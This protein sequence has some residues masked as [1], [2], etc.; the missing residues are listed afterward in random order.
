MKKISCGCDDMK[1]EWNKKYTTISV[2]ILIVAAIGMIV[3]QAIANLPYIFNLLGTFIDI[4]SPFLLG[5]V[6]AYILYPVL[7]L[8]EEVVLPFITGKKLSRRTYR[9]LSIFITILLGISAVAVLFYFIIPELLNNVNVLISQIAAYAPTVENALNEFFTRFHMAESLAPIISTI[10]SSVQEFF[11]QTFVFISKSLG[12]VINATINLTTTIINIFVGVFIAIYLWGSKEKFIAQT[13]KL[14]YAYLPEKFVNKAI[15]L[16]QEA[17]KIFGGFI[18]GKIVDSAIIGVLCYVGMLI[19]DI[20]YALLISVIVGVTNI[21]PYFGPFIGAIPS[22]LLL[23]M[24]DPIEALWF[25]VFVLVLQQLDGSIIGPKI[26]GE[27]TGLTAIWVI[28]SVTVF[29]GIF[30]F[31]GMLVGV[32]LFAMIYAIVKR[33][34]NDRL[35]KKNLS[36]NTND[37]A[38]EEN[39][40]IKKG[41]RKIR[42]KKNEKK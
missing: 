3:F 1:F 16:L 6:F 10:T 36:T 31:V 18:S 14:S 20:P 2:Y 21:I 34:V 41:E 28:F 11:S 30:G 9:N 8:F 5:L 4:I 15:A 37:Y 23:L 32:P 22:I 27:S 26:L 42:G 35:T 7:R 25:G 24:V 29:G 13:K 19:L 38:S 17:N 40:I 33:S 12:S 39:K